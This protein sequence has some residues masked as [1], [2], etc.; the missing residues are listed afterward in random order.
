M[1]LPAGGGSTPPSRLTLIAATASTS[2]TSTTGPANAIDQN[3]ST[4]WSSAWTAPQY[5]QLDFG[6]VKDIARV[7]INWE[8]AY[9]KDYQLLIS[10]DGNS[11]TPIHAV[12]NG[13]GG[14]D[15]ITGLAGRGRYLRINGT[16][17]ATSYGYSLYEVEVYGPTTAAPSST[18]LQAEAYNAMQ[19][20]QVEAT[21]DAGGGQNVGYVDATDWLSYY[22]VT[23]PTSGTYTIEY[24]VA[25]P[26]GGALTADLADLN[27]N[28]T[29]LGRVTIPATG[30]WQTWRT[31]TQSVSVN[32]GTYNFG[33]YAQTG[34]WNLNWLRIS[35]AGSARPALAG[36]AAGTGE[37]AVSV[38]PNP[39]TDRLRVQAA[40]ELL[41]RPYQI[42]DAYGQPKGGGTLSTGEV[43]VSSLAPGVY[44][45]LI[46]TKEQQKINQQFIKQ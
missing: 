22:N 45:L 32:A 31:V 16:R 28:T 37:L 5:L 25:S 38:Y 26:G 42:L 39:V 8:A 13:D 7:K 19:G 21:T 46:V 43:A 40:P 44:R 17:R 30:G 27:A 12:L 41:G 35:K 6:T 3:L 14:F 15:D 29:A 24:R 2:Q 18:L 36:E 20:I 9:A 34:G 1:S 10:S 33:L 11:W 4:R 23:F